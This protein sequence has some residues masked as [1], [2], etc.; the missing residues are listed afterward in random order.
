MELLPGGFGR[1]GEG[2]GEG[3]AALRGTR[4]GQRHEQEQEPAKVPSGGHRGLMA[5]DARGSR[6]AA[7][8]FLLSSRL[9]LRMVRL[10]LLMSRNTMSAVSV[11]ARRAVCLFLKQKRER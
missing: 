9:F 11:S 7:V 1:Q 4:T 6:L 3:D 5:E 10:L 2:E 8:Q